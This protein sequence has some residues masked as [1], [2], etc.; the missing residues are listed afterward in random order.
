MSKNT[1][2]K[3]ELDG[4]RRASKEAHGQRPERP[5]RVCGPLGSGAGGEDN[6]VR[7][8]GSPLI[9]RVL[10]QKQD[11]CTRLF[12]LINSHELAGAVG[13]DDRVHIGARISGGPIAD[14]HAFPV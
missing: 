6:D 8:V 2:L 10:L 11:I 12:Q 3:T 5:L 13:A 7:K 14:D 1:R 9:L 4:A